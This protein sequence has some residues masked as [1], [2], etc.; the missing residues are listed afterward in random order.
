MII[1]GKEMGNR[2]VIKQKGSSW[3]VWPAVIDATIERTGTTWTKLIEVNEKKN[4]KKD[5]MKLMIFFHFILTRA[6][7]SRKKISLP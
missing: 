4:K 6:I 2:T 7:L 3:H 5:S 1:A